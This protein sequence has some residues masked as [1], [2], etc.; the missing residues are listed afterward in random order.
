VCKAVFGVLLV[1]LHLVVELLVWLLRVLVWH[2]V[3]GSTY[4]C[5]SSFMVSGRGNLHCV[6]HFFFEEVCVG[7]PGCQQP[8][9]ED[10][11]ASLMFVGRGNTRSICV[12]HCFG[13]KLGVGRQECRCSQVEDSTAEAK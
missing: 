5:A 12:G 7:S 11:G 3:G 1:W 8:W 2:M 4:R 6:G 9:V 13:K 10:Q